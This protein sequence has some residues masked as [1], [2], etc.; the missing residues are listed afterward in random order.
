MHVVIS[1]RELLRGFR[2]VQGVIEKRNVM[3]ILSNVLL[4]TRDGGVEIFATDLEI[5]IRGFYSADVKKPGRV[6]VSAGTLLDILKELPETDVVMSTVME[7]KFLSIRC[8]MSQFKVTALSPD[9]FPKMPVTIGKELPEIPAGLLLRMLTNT[10]YAVGEHD[11][12]YMLNGVNVTVVKVTVPSTKSVLRC[13]GTDG[14]RLAVAELDIGDAQAVGDVGVIIPK[15]AAQEIRKLLSE[16]D[17]ERNEE[18]RLGITDNQLILRMSGILL[19]ARLIDGAYPDYEQVIPVGN[20]RKVTLDKASFE[21]AIRRV[22][23]LSPDRVNT[24]HLSFESDRVVLHSSTSDRG[25]ATDELAATYGGEAF[26]AVFNARYLLDSLASIE[27]ERCCL[28]DERIV[29]PLSHQRRWPGSHDVRRHA[30]EGV[31]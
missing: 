23:L 11:T 16:S 18:P 10:T 26:N 14:H 8:G 15:K 22:A 17:G 6:A 1:R 30:D 25:E 19:S 9:D 20:D 2:R 4:E 5:G 24:I 29:E 12:R 3:P 31:R 7:G 21:T 27:G 28:R 13:V